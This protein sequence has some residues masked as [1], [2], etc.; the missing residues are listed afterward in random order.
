MVRSTFRVSAQ[1]FLGRY[2][3][4]REKKDILEEI[5]REEKKEIKR[6]KQEEEEV[7]LTLQKGWRTVFGEFVGEKLQNCL[8]GSNGE[9]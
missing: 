9:A 7:R 4:Q 2:L 3:C 1:Y 5:S 8:Q 6:P